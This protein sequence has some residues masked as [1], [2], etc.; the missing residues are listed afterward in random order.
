MKFFDTHCHLN[1]S[2]FQSDLDEVLQRAI[3]SGVSRILVPGW[4]L[5][6]SRT[7]IELA[8]KHPQIVA[9]VGLHPTEIVYEHPLPIDEIRELADQ[10]EVVA[11]G[12]IG[13]DYHHDPDHIQEQRSLLV[14]ML[15]IARDVNKKVILH[16]RESME[17]IKQIIFDWVGTNCSSENHSMKFEGVF[18][19][20]EGNL[21][22]SLELK[23]YGFMFGVGG[24]LTYKNAHTKQEVFSA[25]S[26][27][28][29]CL[30]TDAPYLAPAR[31]RG[32]RNEPSYLPLVG[33]SLAKLRNENEDALLNR[34]FENSYKMFIKDEAS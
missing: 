3:D 21:Q 10:P 8:R 14:E 22:D 18:H 26:F 12:E 34:I 2:S 20:F 19:A 5:E 23:Q 7:A 32:E 24:P 9:A 28:A 1:H 29:I 30:E 13:L 11:I 6:S 25:L 4:D 15:N 16:S 17:D 27:D 31:H 33:E